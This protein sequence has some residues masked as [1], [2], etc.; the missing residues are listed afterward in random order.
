MSTTDQRQETI[1][2][3]KPQ[4]A[5]NWTGLELIPFETA[6]ERFLDPVWSGMGQRHARS[7]H[8]C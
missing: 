8:L 2:R 5:T 7:H 4:Q 1:E 3:V 6:I